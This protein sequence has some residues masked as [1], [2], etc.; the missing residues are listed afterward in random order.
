MPVHI[1][2]KRDQERTPE[3]GRKS[4]GSDLDTSVPEWAENMEHVLRRLIRAR[5]KRR[6]KSP[7]LYR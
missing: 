5:Q 2:N 3:L 4:N 7:G 6:D 1:D